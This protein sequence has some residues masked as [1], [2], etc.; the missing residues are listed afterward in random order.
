M[1]F[2]QVIAKFDAHYSKLTEL[3]IQGHF[4]ERVIDSD[5]LIPYRGRH[6]TRYSQYKFT[7]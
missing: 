6:M 4:Y 5:S 7:E 1:I 2:A 3:I